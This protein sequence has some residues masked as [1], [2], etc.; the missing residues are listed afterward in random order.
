MGTAPPVSIDGFNV[1][2]RIEDPDTDRIMA[3]P[4]PSLEERLI[5]DAKFVPEPEKSSY[6]FRHHRIVG[7]MGA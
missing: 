4:L 5:M 6:L 1:R 2:S 3:Q 7:P